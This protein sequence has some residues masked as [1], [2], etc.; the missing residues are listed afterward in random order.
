MNRWRLALLGAISTAGIGAVI[1]SDR[2]AQEQRYH[3]FADQREACG[4]PRFLDVVSNAA[5]AIAG[6]AGWRNVRQRSHGAL[7][8]LANVYRTF[9]GSGVLVAFGSAFY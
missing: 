3:E 7:P 5:F 8:G 9:F 1:L 6:I 2:I 4:V